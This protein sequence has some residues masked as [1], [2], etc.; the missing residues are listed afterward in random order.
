MRNETAPDK[1]RAPEGPA[2]P[3]IA[4][5]PKLKRA[6]MHVLAR[7]L[8]IDPLAGPLGPLPVTDTVPAAGKLFYGATRSQ[9]YRMARDPQKDA[10]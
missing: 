7:R 9:S 4:V 10:P 6:L 8:G 5:G 2:I 3:T 1:A